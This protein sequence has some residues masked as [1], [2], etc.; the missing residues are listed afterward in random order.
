MDDCQTF[1]KTFTVLIHLQLIGMVFYNICFDILYRDFTLYYCLSQYHREPKFSTALAPR[2]IDVSIVYKK[3]KK[4]SKN[5]HPAPVALG[6]RGAPILY[7]A[8]ADSIFIATLFPRKFCHATE[9]GS[10]T[11]F[12]SLKK[13]HRFVMNKNFCAG[14]N[15]YFRL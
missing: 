14:L 15:L 1:F 4:V 9:T 13:V 2:S 11:V 3:K 7:C 8:G 6:P 5:H 12:P 10:F